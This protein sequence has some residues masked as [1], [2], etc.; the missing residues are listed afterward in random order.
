MNANETDLD[1][2]CLVAL[3]K[4]NILAKRIRELEQVIE[5]TQ[6]QVVK[7]IAVNNLLRQIL[8]F[9]G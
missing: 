8:E 2:E 4:T 1:F 7:M 3:A 5:P 6:E 9:M